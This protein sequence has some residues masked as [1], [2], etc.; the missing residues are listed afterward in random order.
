M[1]HGQEKQEAAGGRG[2]ALG[3]MSGLILYAKTRVLRRSQTGT[4]KTTVRIVAS[5]VDHYS[6]CRA[7]LRL[8]CRAAQG[9][10]SDTAYS[11]S[12]TATTAESHT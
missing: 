2:V 10:P 6:D 12:T 7:K 5:N 3:Y 8:I 9:L 4:S 11:A 1:D